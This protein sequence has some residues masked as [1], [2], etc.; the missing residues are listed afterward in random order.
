[1]I[2]IGLVGA[3]GR[4]GV[5]IRGL[6][7][8][9]G[10][11]VGRLFVRPGATVEAPSVGHGPD[12]LV[13]VDVVIDVSTPQTC[14]AYAEEAARRGLPFVTGTTGLT[15]TQIAALEAHATQIP[16]LHAANFSVGVNV[17]EHVVE[18]VA[19]A[20]SGFDIEVFEAHHRRKVD[21]PGGTALMLGKSAARGRGLN[22]DHAAVYERHG[23]TGPRASDAIGFQVLRGGG[24]IGEHTV[25]FADEGERIELTHRA[26]DR[27]IFAKGAIRAAA[28]LH[29]KDPGVYTMRDVLFS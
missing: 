26:Q 6:L 15:A 29:G 24:I 20:T 28:W 9:A 27:A 4:M 16:V 5:A 25:F 14:L 13:D 22:F 21:A 7:P 12:E 17:L 18:L 3:N 2:R 8:A 19:R 23:H 10:V 1:M 11:R